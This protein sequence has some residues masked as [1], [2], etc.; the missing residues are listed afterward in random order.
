[1]MTM[2]MITDFS[3][4]FL[5]IREISILH[6]RPIDKRVISMAKSIHILYYMTLYTLCLALPSIVVLCLQM[7][8][9]YLPLMIISL[10]LLDFLIVVMTSLLYVFVLKSFD[11]EKLKDIITFF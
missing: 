3:N 10:I 6:T 7:G 8:L 5:D 4:V 9:V 2:V 11:G 1:M